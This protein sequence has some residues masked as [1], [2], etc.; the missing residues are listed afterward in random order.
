MLLAIHIENSRTVFGI[1]NGPAID[2][3][4]EFSN[5][6]G[7]GPGDNQSAFLDS[8]A[9]VERVLISS[10]VPIQTDRIARQVRTSLGLAPTLIDASLDLGLHYAIENPADLGANLIV[11]SLAATERES[12]AV[13]V[14]DFG[15]TNAFVGI[16]SD[17][18][19]RGVAI[20]PGLAASLNA[21]VQGTARLPY[22]QP[23]PATHVLGTTTAGAIQG[24]MTFG[25]SGMVGAILDR[26]TEELGEETTVV[27]TG[28]YTEL[29]RGVRNRLHIVEPLLPLYGLEAADRRLRAG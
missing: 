19:V 23:A 21:L 26:I 20:V 10:V 27:A 11:E 2:L 7:V 24:G 1:F 22:V 18:I 15:N 12:G 4:R 28:V 6:P 17:R 25:Y 8:F 14:V 9:G 29:Y 5:Q 16:S 3:V 13:I